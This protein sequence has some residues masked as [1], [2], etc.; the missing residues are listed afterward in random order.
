MFTWKNYPSTREA[1]AECEDCGKRLVSWCV[2][3]VP[4]EV[5]AE[6]MLGRALAASMGHRCE[7]ADE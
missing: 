1:G 3:H 5:V 2:D 6:V 4:E 7:V